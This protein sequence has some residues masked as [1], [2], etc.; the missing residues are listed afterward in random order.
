MNECFICKKKSTFNGYV[1]ISDGKYTDIYLCRSHYLK[2]CKNKEIVE[3]RKKNKHIKPL[4]KEWEKMCKKEQSLFDMWMKK[5][6][7]KQ[8]GS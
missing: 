7:K 8:V 2:W 1:A 5:E 3:F 4:T 6:L